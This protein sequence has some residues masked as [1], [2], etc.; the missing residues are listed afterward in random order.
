MDSQFKKSK[1]ATAKALKNYEGVFKGLK[2]LLTRL[3]ELIKEQLDWLK[4]TKT[5][6]V[7]GTYLKDGKLSTNARFESLESAT[8][9]SEN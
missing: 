1:L 9:R 6:I 7:S 5:E 3:R 2:N 8:P 4:K